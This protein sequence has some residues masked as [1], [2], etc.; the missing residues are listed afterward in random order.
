MLPQAVRFPSCF[1]QRRGSNLGPNTKLTSLRLLVVLVS[2]LRQIPGQYFILGNDL[3]FPHL[4]PI[5]FFS[6]P[7]DHMMPYSPATDIAPRQVLNN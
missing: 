2:L 4:F 7:P 6:L 1:R 5:H 3:F